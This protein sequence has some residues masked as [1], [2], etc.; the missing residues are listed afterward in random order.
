LSSSRIGWAGMPQSTAPGSTS[1]VI[2]DLA[3]IMA[4]SP[5]LR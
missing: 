1:L 3:P 2:P 4:P 5:I